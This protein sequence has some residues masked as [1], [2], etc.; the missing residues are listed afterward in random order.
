MKT[1]RKEA[2]SRETYNSA[3]GKFTSPMGDTTTENSNLCN[4]L[5]RGEVNLGSYFIPLKTEI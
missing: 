1:I 3:Q 5:I 2:Q 4:V